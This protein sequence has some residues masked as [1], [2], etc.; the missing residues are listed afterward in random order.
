MDCAQIREISWILG[1]QF[2]YT[3]VY[4]Y[5]IV[6]GLSF[7]HTYPIPPFPVV[8]LVYI[9]DRAYHFPLS[10]GVVLSNGM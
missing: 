4:V 9:G 5:I 8:G 3:E 7:L 1:V 10:S 2:R 6:S